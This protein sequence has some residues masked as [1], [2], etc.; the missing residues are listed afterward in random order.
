[1]FYATKLHRPGASVGASAGGSR[2]KVTAVAV[3]E[4]GTK[5]SK[6]IRFTHCLPAAMESSTDMWIASIRPESHSQF[7]FSEIQS[8]LGGTW[9]ADSD[10][11]SK[12]EI[13][14]AA[15]VQSRPA[16]NKPVS[17]ALANCHM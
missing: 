5:F 15:L 11:S 16:G 17:A 6:I 14:R 13:A 2:Q 9:P 7:L 1:M 3:R 8:S 10:M 12:A 4:R